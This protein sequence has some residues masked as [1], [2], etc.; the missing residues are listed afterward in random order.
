MNIATFIK[1]HEPED[2]PIHHVA[3]RDQ[4]VYRLSEPIGGH[5]HVLVSAIRF[6]PESIWRGAETMVFAC[7]AEGG[8]PKGRWASIDAGPFVGFDHDAALRKVGY[9]PVY[10]L[11]G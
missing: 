11:C 10:P 8:E 9:L 5:D 1:K 4:R 2:P 6:K 7:D 3:E